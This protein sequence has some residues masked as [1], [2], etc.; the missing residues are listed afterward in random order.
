MRGVPGWCGT[1]TC[2]LSGVFVVVERDGFGLLRS[3][4]G[5]GV[6]RNRRGGRFGPTA[7]STLESL[8][9]LHEGAALLVDVRVRGE[10]VVLRH[11]RRGTPAA[12]RSITTSA[13]TVAATGSVPPVRSRPRRRAAKPE[14]AHDAAGVR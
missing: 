7:R 11:D 5:V 9:A 6:E 10:I 2:L 14:D 3:V 4:G 1:H 12:G 8:A 13:I